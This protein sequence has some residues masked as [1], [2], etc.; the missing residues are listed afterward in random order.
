MDASGPQSIGTPPPG[1]PVPGG[2]TSY[3]S[4]DKHI[5]LVDPYSMTEFLTFTVPKNALLSFDASFADPILVPEPW[6]LTLLAGA[7]AGL[8]LLRRRS[9]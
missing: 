3:A 7:L 6:S 1:D 2:P 8:G 5:D 9:A 4:A